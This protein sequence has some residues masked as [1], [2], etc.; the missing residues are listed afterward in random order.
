MGQ[1]I[2]AAGR[3]QQPGQHR[4]LIGR[5]PRRRAVEILARLRIDAI[6]AGAQVDPV[7]VDGQDLVLGEPMLQPQGQQ[8]LLNFAFYRPFRGQKQVL[9]HLLGDRRPSLNDAPGLEVGLHGPRQADDVEAEVAKEAPVLGRQHGLDQGPGQFV[10]P[11]RPAVDVADDGKLGAVGGQHRHRRAAGGVEGL[12]HVRQLGR[13]PS[14]Q[15]RKRDYR[16]NSA[17]GAP[18]QRFGERPLDG[19]PQ[20]ALAFRSLGLVFTDFSHAVNDRAWRLARG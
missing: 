11:G 20:V 7:Q 2:V 8:K 19:P 9:R 12:L 5:Q 15:H 18:F 13:V 16:P 4:R 10:E 6:G 14:R 1:G 3:L 17:D